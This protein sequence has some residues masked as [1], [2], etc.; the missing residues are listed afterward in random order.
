MMKIARGLAVVLL[1]LA[2]VVSLAPPAAAG[3]FFTLAS[4]AARTAPGNGTATVTGN[5]RQFAIYVNVT[6][7]SGTVGTFRVWLEATADGTN[8]VEVPCEM[9][10]KTGA[11]APGTAAA[12]ARDIVNETAVQTAAK[13]TALCRTITNQVRIAWNIAGT[14]P[15]ETFSVIAY[16]Y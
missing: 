13:Y 6:A 3:E 11:A 8:W 12:A 5:W 14:T 4:S 2:L 16:G 9:A 7:G 15:S 10:V 1:A